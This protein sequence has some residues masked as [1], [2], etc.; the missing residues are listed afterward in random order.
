MSLNTTLY[1]PGAAHWPPIDGPKTSQSSGSSK[2]SAIFQRD[3]CFIPC[4][5]VSIRDNLT[6]VFELSDV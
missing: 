1:A 6:S 3:W 4:R 2:E 5:G